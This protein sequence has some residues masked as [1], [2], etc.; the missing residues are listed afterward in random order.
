MVTVSVTSDIEWDKTLCNTSIPPTPICPMTPTS[1]TARV[2]PVAVPCKHSTLMT[3]PALSR[4]HLIGTTPK[5]RSLKNSGDTAS[6]SCQHRHTP[7]GQT[8]TRSATF[9]YGLG[10]KESRS[11]TTLRLLRSQTG[12]NLATS[13]MRLRRTLNPKQIFDWPGSRCVTWGRIQASPSTVLLH[14]SEFWARSVI[15]KIQPNW[16]TSWSTKLLSGLTTLPS[17]KSS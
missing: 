7:N 13:G 11:S 12:I 3:C 17:G 1:L 10:P 5:F 14:V 16:M 15:S 6:W 8:K 2:R 9:C 4:Q